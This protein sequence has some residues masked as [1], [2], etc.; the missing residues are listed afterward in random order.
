MK[1][2]YQHTGYNYK[3]WTLDLVIRLC[4]L[5]TSV[6]WKYFIEWAILKKKKANLANHTS[7]VS[8]EFVQKGKVLAKIK[9]DIFPLLLSNTAHCFYQPFNKLK[10]IGKWFTVECSNSTEK[11]I[12]N[13]VILHLLYYN[14]VQLWTHCEL[15]RENGKK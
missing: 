5:H 14:C 11:T 6:K 7:C 8:E 10:N 4:A 1:Q 3:Y 2:Y 15:G 13:T 9:Y 12:C